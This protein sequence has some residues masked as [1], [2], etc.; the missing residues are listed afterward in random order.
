MDI[1]TVTD[2]PVMFIPHVELYL[3]FNLLQFCANM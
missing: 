2:T 3:K 1:N